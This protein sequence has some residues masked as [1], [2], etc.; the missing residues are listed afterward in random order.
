MRCD[1][2]TGAF[3]PAAY[4]P[5]EAKKVIFPLE[6]DKQ[7]LPEFSQPVVD[8]MNEDLAQ[9]MRDV[10]E[11]YKRLRKPDPRGAAVPVTVAEVRAQVRTITTKPATPERPP[12]LRSYSK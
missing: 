5:V 10:S 4:W 8:Q 2:A 6:K 1:L 7:V 11:I 12:T 9:F 3:C